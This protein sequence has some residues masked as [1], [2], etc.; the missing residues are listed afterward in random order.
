MNHPLEPDPALGVFSTMLVV[1]GR[2]VELDAHLAQ[3]R[4]SVRALFGLALPGWAAEAVAEKARGLELGRVRL[5]VA[6]ADGEPRLEALARSLDRAVVLRDG[7]LDLCSTTVSGWHGAHKWVDRRLLDGL[8][9]AV[10]PA[11]ALLVEPDGRVLE[12]TRANVFALCDDGVLRTPPADGAIL[13]GVT[14]AQ[15]IAIAE[16]AGLPVCEEPLRLD[17]LHAAREVFA[18]GSIRGVEPVRS[19]DGVP[20]GSH[21]DVATAIADALRRRYADALR[22]ARSARSSSMRMTRSPSRP[23]T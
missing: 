19:L 5:S 11:G 21:R 1:D 10:A 7:A 23:A 12:T 4:A 3:L 14:R 17:A 2:P 13:P 22:C 16:E 20:V 18:T 15:A 6:A 9:A 8:D